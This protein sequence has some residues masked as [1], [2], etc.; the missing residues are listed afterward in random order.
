MMYIQNYLSKNQLL[1]NLSMTYFINFNIKPNSNLNVH[2]IELQEVK[3]IKNTK[4]P[5]LNIDRK[6]SWDSHIDHVAN[7]LFSGTV[8]S[9]WIIQNLAVRY[10]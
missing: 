6:L 8:C 4:F 7:Q 2:T 10:F 9:V 5:G 3:E 1:L